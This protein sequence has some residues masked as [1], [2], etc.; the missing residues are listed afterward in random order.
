MPLHSLR[1]TTASLLLSA[2]VPAEQAAKLLGHR[3][4]AIFYRVYA[5]L[6]R[7]GAQDAAQKLSR[8]LEL[9]ETAAKATSTAGLANPFQSASASASC[10]R[11][12]K[13]PSATSSERQPF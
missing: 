5:D 4:L 8:Y 7:P 2:G 9:Q 10:V 12:A 13:K 3:S 1:H 6:L 11:P